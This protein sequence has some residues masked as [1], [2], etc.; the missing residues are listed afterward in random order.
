MAAELRDELPQYLRKGEADLRAVCASCIKDMC[1]YKTRKFWPAAWNCLE[2]RHLP[3]IEEADS[4]LVTFFH[5]VPMAYVS[6]SSR[7]VG[8]LFPGLG[9]RLKE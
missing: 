2:I 4:L 7:Q 9:A 5:K 1:G 6:N 3:K 8:Q